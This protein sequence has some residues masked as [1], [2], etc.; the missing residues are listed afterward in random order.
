MRETL[1]H[2]GRWGEGKRKGAKSFEGEKSL[3]S[4]IQEILS[5]ADDYRVEW[6]ANTT[7]NKSVPSYCALIVGSLTVND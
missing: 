5:A 1:L 3:S 2:G 7:K 4:L 6:L